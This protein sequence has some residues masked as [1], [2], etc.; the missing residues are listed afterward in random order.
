MSF[1]RAHTREHERA[2]ES[3]KMKNISMQNGSS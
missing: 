3:V 1:T 2:Y